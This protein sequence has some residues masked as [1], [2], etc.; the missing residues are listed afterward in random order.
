MKFTLEEI[1]K[2]K[3]LKKKKHPKKEPVYT[4][5]PEEDVPYA[6]HDFSKYIDTTYEDDEY[7]SQ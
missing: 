6:K 5:L 1:E 7:D 3:K 4:H 2:D